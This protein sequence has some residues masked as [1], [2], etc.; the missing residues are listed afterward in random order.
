MYSISSKKKRE[1]KK[2]DIQF[3]LIQNPRQFM[4]A[5]GDKW[6]A[7][8]KYTRSR[9]PEQLIEKCMFTRNQRL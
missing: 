9:K 7:G 1:K 8:S 6:V 2:H 4:V 3:H 5:F